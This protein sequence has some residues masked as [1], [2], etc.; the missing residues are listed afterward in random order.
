MPQVVRTTNELIV[1][2]LYL[3]G[4]LGVGEVPD[5]YMLI[6]GIELINEL[7]D[8]FSVDNIYIP[9]L[10]TINFN[11]VAG[12][13]EYSVSDMA[14]GADIT[15]DRIVNLEFANYT[16]DTVVYP[17]R[18]VDKAQYYDLVRIN[19]LQT[20]PSIIFL[21][22]QPL[23]SILTVYP[24]P[25]QPYP[26]FIQVKSMLNK[27]EPFDDLTA[28]PPY[29]YG[30]LKYALARKFLAYYPSG[31]WPEQ[32]ESEYWDY[33]NN[34]K[35]GNETNLTINPSLILTGPDPYYWQ[36]ILAYC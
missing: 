16:V 26:A 36:K 9:Y 28:L 20:R 12:Q 18:I 24:I 3:L 29:Y 23:E 10:T 15:E 4:E 25:D 30:F 7:L 32:N 13:G 19:N 35:A 27:L 5:A 2:A 21:N 11:F 33:Y 34:L 22:K 6:T 17:L 1:N 8:K 31:N 14:V